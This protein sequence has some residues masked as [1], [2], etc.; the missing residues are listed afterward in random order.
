MTSLALKINDFDKQNIV[1]ID[2]QL[3]ISQDKIITPLAEVLHQSLPVSEPKPIS[4]TLKQSLDD[5]FPEQQY[6]EKL[7]QEAKKVL[8]VMAN[9][10][11]QDQL[12]DT[13]TKVQFLAESWLDDFE[14]DIFEGRTLNEL[15]HEKGGL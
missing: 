7:I 2:Q 8:G 14:R 5:L 4:P 10:F 15:L 11:N 1:A 3:P 6:D 13:V 9:E 12:K